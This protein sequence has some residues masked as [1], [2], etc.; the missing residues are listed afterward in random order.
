MAGKKV[1]MP[2]EDQQHEFRD[3]HCI[4]CSAPIGMVYNHALSRPRDHTFVVTQPCPA[5]QQLT[6]DGF[7]GPEG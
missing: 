4:H 2:P 1:E 6:I 5:R 7:A 3:N